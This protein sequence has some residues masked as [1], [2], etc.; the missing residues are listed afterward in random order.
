MRKMLEAIILGVLAGAITGFIAVMRRAAHGYRAHSIQ[1]E[2]VNSR[3][4]L[5]KDPKGCQKQQNCRDREALVY[6]ILCLPGASLL[7]GERC[8]GDECGW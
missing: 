1:P 8:H 7:A 3:F 4:Q 6:E 2:S 5:S